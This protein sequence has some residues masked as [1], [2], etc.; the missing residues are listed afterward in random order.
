MSKI[1]ALDPGLRGCGLAMFHGNVLERCGYVRGAKTG[2]DVDAWAAMAA[3]V[4][5]EI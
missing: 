3:E 5:A 4:D 2:R 1:I